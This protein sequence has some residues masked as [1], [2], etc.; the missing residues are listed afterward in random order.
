MCPKNWSAKRSAAATVGTKVKV[1]DQC[2]GVAD[3]AAD[4][5]V[6]TVAETPKA[7]AKIAARDDD[8]EKPAVKSAKKAGVVAA[9]F[10]AAPKE[11]P[12]KKR[13]PADDD[14]DDRPKS[15]KKGGNGAM[16][17]I[18][19]G[20]VV[21]LGAAAGLGFWLLGDKKKD[22]AGNSSTP[23]TEA[24]WQ[25]INVGTEFSCQLPPDYTP[26]NVD[27][28]AQM[29]NL[30]LQDGHLS[31]PIET[32]LPRRGDAKPRRNSPSDGATT[33]GRDGR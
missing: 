9:A 5:A 6:E 3:E 16:I 19:A 2:E 4:D 32:T 12:A 1:T 8:D 20:V 23:T 29:N 14:D 25:T 15:K 10:A 11:A 7:K 33:P 17:A 30:G 18:V 13:R 22:S 28:A 26:L 27:N 21:L 24:G 31:K